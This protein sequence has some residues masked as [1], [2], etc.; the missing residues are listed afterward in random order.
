MP[1]A[2][3]VDVGLLPV[4]SLAADDTLLDEDVEDENPPEVSFE[5]LEDDE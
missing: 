4:V 5:S 3:D 1:I 2:V